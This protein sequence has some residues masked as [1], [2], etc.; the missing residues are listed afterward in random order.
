MSNQPNQAPENVPTLQ[1]PIQE[2]LDALDTTDFSSATEDEVLNQVSTFINT[3][4]LSRELDPGNFAIFDLLGITPNQYL[5]F[6]QNDNSV[7][8]HLRQFIEAT[9]AKLAEV[10]GLFFRNEYIRNSIIVLSN[11]LS[12][13]LK[14]SDRATL[15]KLAKQYE[16]AAPAPVSPEV[17]AQ[18][19]SIWGRVKGVYAGWK[20]KREVVDSD[21]Y[22]DW[23]NADLASAEYQPDQVQKLYNSKLGL[24]KVLGVRLQG[25]PHDYPTTAK[26]LQK[27]YLKFSKVTHPDSPNGNSALFVIVDKEIWS[28][29]NGYERLENYL[30]ANDV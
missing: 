4:R 28:S 25:N 5:E 27:A 30:I 10:K 23:E 13:L 8:E 1:N 7:R 21:P 26:E 29:R 12:H 6:Y 20:A 3:Y 14:V 15:T 11:Y 2:F 16:T 19:E 24:F 18:R 17:S 9:L 22:L